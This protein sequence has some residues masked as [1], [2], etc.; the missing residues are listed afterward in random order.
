MTKTRRMGKERGKE[1]KEEGEVSFE[2][3]FP[4]PSFSFASS[5]NPTEA[6]KDVP[7]KRFPSFLVSTSPTKSWREGQQ[8]ELEWVV[9]KLKRKEGDD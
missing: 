8:S 4:F 5:S 6:K 9:A 7:R 3:S 2:R 1:R